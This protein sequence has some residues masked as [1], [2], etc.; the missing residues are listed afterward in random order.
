[1]GRT[2]CPAYCFLLL[3]FH[4]HRPHQQAVAVGTRRRVVAAAGDQGQPGQRLVF[5][6]SGGV[7]GSHLDHAAHGVDVARRS[8]VDDDQVAIPQGI[9]ISERPGGV[10]GVPDVAGQDRVAVRCGVGR[11]VQPAGV[12]PAPLPRCAANRR[13]TLA[14]NGIHASASGLA[15]MFPSSIY[16]IR[17]NRNAKMVFDELS[18]AYPTGSGLD[19]PSKN[20]QPSEA[21]LSRPYLYP[22]CFSCRIGRLPGRNFPKNVDR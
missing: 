10:V 22:V 12:V 2:K 18:A 15:A 1:M 17:L 5:E 20:S 16:G 21:E 11:A 14:A 3:H 7:P 4:Q 6:H 8:G 9:E 19:H 13:T